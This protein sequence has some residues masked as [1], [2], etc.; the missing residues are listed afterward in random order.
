MAA[1]GLFFATAALTGAASLAGLPPSAGTAVACCL[2]AVFTWRRVDRGIHSV[3]ADTL[4][5]QPFGSEV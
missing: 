1:A 4:L 2:G 5:C 3:L